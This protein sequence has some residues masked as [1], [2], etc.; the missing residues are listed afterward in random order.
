MRS[1]FRALRA[2]SIITL[3]FFSWTYLP[4]YQIAAYAATKQEKTIPTGS[5]R[6]SAG[7]SEKFEKLLE[8]LRDKTRKAEEKSGKGEDSTSEIEAIKSR[9]AEIEALDA[10]LRKDFAATEK[11]LYDANLPKEIL[12]RHSKFVKNYED[13]LS[14]LRANIDAIEKAKTPAALKADVAKTRT[15]LEKVKPL[16]K[17]VPLD[18]NKLPNRIVKAKERQPK[19]KKEEWEREFKKKPT[20]PKKVKAAQWQ[21]HKPII[22]ASNGSLAGLLSGMDYPQLAALP[23]DGL[24]QTAQTD[25]GKHPFPPEIYPL[26]WETDMTPEDKVETPE[27]H[28]TDAIRAKAAELQNNPI[29]MFNWLRNNIY[30]VPSYGSIQGADMCLQTKQCNATDI[31]SLTIAMFRA[32]DWPARYVFQTVELDI[33]RFMENMGGFTDPQAAISFAAS[34][35]IPVRPVISGGKITAVQFEHVYATAL[36]PMGYYVGVESLMRRGWSQPMW[37]PLDVSL[38]HYVTTPGIDISTA[39]PFDAQ[40]FVNQIQSTATIN[41]AEGYVTNVNSAFIQQTMQNYQARVQDYISQNTPTATVGDVLGKREIKQDNLP[42][43]YPTGWTKPVTARVQ[44]HTLPDSMKS[45][46]TFNV[47]DPLG[48][49]NGLSYTTTLPQ[50]AGKKITLS[51]SPATAADQAV[52]ESYLPKAY[53]DGTPIQLS[54]LPSSLPAY[55][56]YLKPEL[57]IDGQVVASGAAVTMGAEVAFNISLSEPGI[58]PSQVN[59]TILAGEYYGIGLDVGKIRADQVNALKAKLELTKTKMEAQN[60][61][62]LTKENLVGDLL[63]TTISAY[64]AQLDMDDEVN[65]QL[66]GVVRYRAPSIGMF[67]LKMD[68]RGIF[69]VPTSAGSKGMM[70][71]VDRIMQAVLSKDGNMDTVRAYMLKS[72]SNS[73]AQENTVPEQLYSR[74]DNPVS[75]ISAVKA[76]RI[77]NDQSIPIYTINGSNI[78]VILPQLQI[79]DSVKSDIMNAISAGKEVTV[80]KT[81][82][83]LSGWTGCGYIIIDPTTGAGAYMISGGSNGAWIAGGTAVL[84]FLMAILAGFAAIPVIAAVILMVLFMAIAFAALYAETVCIYGKNTSDKFNNCIALVTVKHVLADKL[85]HLY[86]AINMVKLLAKLGLAVEGAESLEHCLKILSEA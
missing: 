61:S 44:S 75:G 65:A 56:I 68:V 54:E 51:F 12:D 28:I 55:L 67:S 50:I 45:S 78:N 33:D 53:T 70:M 63:Y 36:L 74:P 49:E 15:H 52:I 64:F 19:L 14:E 21:Q 81:N 2:V 24:I 71:D 48:F 6:Q 41:E 9:K 29:L 83:S 17:H 84:F 46:I 86:P 59:N 25:Y 79:D 20:K 39:V 40:S 3:I 23:T 27:T 35:G 31:A 85:L 18:P 22:V 32:A 30:L 73:S 5:S 7:P 4:L 76:L 57:R 62:D 13:N 34:G 72:G 69:N 82:V 38:K 8:E 42:H 10:D 58:G 11:K 16:K 66:I 60:Y 77:A 37:M 1:L 26:P 43:L 80:S 47:P